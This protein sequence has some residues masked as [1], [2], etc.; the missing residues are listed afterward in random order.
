MVRDHINIT[1][2]LNFLRL[3][4]NSDISLSFPMRDTVFFLLRSLW[5]LFKAAYIL[6]AGNIANIFCKKRAC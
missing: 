5:L 6:I 3:N 2:L 1:F 4:A